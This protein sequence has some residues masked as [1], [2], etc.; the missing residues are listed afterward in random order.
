MASDDMSHDLLI[1]FGP[2]PPVD[3]P[4]AGSVCFEVCSGVCLGG[5]PVGN[6]LAA[7]FSATRLKDG[8]SLEE[9]SIAVETEIGSASAQVAY[10]MMG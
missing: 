5:A 4:P 9:I 1:F 10:K 2:S 6:L 8:E 7:S 3:D